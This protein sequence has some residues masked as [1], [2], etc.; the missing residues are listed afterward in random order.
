MGGLVVMVGRR[1]L[2]RRP[3]FACSD[4]RAHAAGWALA[5]TRTCRCACLGL[6]AVLDALLREVSARGVWVSAHPDVIARMGTKEVLYTTRELG[7]GTD[8]ALYR[9]PAEFALRFPAGLPARW[10]LVL[11]QG[12]G[13]GGTGVWK[14]E[15]TDTHHGTP[16]PDAVLRVQ[17]AQTRDTATEQL[18]LAA[19]LHHCADYFPGPA[20]WSTSRSSTAWPT[21]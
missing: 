19:F 20:S 3:S 7:W 12:R 11:K 10:V 18:S 5:N 2:P 14:V 9:T 6:I 13:T 21:G 4:P 16:T 8:T 17:P 15:L 1:H